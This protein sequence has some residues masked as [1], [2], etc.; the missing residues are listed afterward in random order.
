MSYSVGLSSVTLVIG[1]S[2]TQPAS[3][4]EGNVIIRHAV[5][6]LVAPEK[7]ALSI[8]YKYKF[9]GRETVHIVGISTVPS[10][11]SF[12]YITEGKSLFF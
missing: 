2:L 7:R 11:G 5:A 6:V 12:Q 10:E 9:P 1:F 4:D 8:D 3:A